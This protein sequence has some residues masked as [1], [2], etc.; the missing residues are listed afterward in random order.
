MPFYCQADGVGPKAFV[1]WRARQRAVE[2]IAD[3]GD[4][5]AAQDALFAERR[6]EA[7]HV[8]RNGNGP[9]AHGLSSAEVSAL[10]LGETSVVTEGDPDGFGGCVARLI[11]SEEVKLDLL[12]P[13]CSG[14]VRFV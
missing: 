10:I 1:D 9:W 14:P 4:R 11:V 3:E 12:C 8:V 2:A 5:Q 6:A 13:E 7:S